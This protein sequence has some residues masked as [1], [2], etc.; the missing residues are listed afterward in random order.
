MMRRIFVGFFFLCTVSFVRAQQTTFFTDPDADYRKGM[1]LLQQE[2][3][4]AAQ[5]KFR[6]AIVRIGQ[7]PA[8]TS[9]EL[10]IHAKYYDALCSKE[11]NRPDAEKLFSDLIEE[12]EKNATVRRAYFQLGNIYFDQ[13]K[14][15]KALPKYRQVDPADLSDDEKAVYDFRLATC[16]FYQKDFDKARPVFEKLRTTQNEYYYP[17]NY[18][19]AYIAYKQGDFQNALKSFRIAWQ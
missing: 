4:A 10:L 11:L 15:N 18:Y 1:E 3:Y 6:E 5:E 14:Y 9:H 8:A 2:K 7:M 17:A 16:Y 12:N 19:Y 13:K